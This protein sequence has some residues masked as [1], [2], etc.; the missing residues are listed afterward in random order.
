MNLP[1]KA[2]GMKQVSAAWRAPG[3]YSCLSLLLKGSGICWISN[4]CKRRWGSKALN[5]NF[6]WKWGLFH[7]VGP[8]KGSPGECGGSGLGGF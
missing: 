6:C 2:A 1:A 4:C 3:L 8:A 5:T 7:S